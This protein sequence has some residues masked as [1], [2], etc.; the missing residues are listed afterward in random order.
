MQQ[1]RD[2]TLTLFAKTGR[3]FE[4]SLLIVISCVNVTKFSYSQTSRYGHLNNID[5]S[6]L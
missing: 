2:G 3:C 6:I 1:T 4:S 5:N